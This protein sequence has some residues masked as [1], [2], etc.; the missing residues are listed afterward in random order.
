[1]AKKESEK[2]DLKAIDKARKEGH[3]KWHQWRAGRSNGR[4]IHPCGHRKGRT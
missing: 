2:K 4:H 1:M 3:Q